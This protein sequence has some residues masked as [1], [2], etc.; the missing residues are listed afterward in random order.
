MIRPFSV[1]V[2]LSALEDFSSRIALTRWP[3]EI[4]GADWDYGY[5][6]TIY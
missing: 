6:L 1:H 3:D 4:D 5:N 2:P